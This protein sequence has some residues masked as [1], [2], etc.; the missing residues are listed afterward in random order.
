MRAWLINTYSQWKQGRTPHQMKSAIKTTVSLSINSPACLYGNYSWHCHSAGQVP[1]AIAS[2][3]WEEHNNFFAT[4]QCCEEENERTWAPQ[5]H[6]LLTPILPPRWQNLPSFKV[7]HGYGQLFAPA[8]HILPRGFPWIG[9]Q[10]DCQELAEGARLFAPGRHNPQVCLHLKNL[11][12][13]KGHL[14]RKC[15][16]R[17]GWTNSHRNHPTCHTNQGYF[18]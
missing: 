11:F 17:L 9:N 3:G 10:F 4:H 14:R 18:H 1:L 2:T 12:A 15:F 5:H 13:F 16:A 6:Q 7:S 8:E